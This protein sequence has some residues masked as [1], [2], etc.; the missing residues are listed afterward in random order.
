M[1]W[2]SIEVQTVFVFY[3]T[4]SQVDQLPYPAPAPVT[5]TARLASLKNIK[6]TTQTPQPKIQHMDTHIDTL[7]RS[8]TRMHAQ[9]STRP[10]KRPNNPPLHNAQPSPALPQARSHAKARQSKNPHKCPPSTN[11][12]TSELEPKTPKSQIRPANLEPFKRGF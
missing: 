11:R 2:A 9:S 3:S 5:R 10:T 6:L 12:L 4:S 7:P 8:P 1:S